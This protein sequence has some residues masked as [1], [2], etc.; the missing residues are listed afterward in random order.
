MAKADIRTL[1]A[2]EGSTNECQGCGGQLR[3]ID[4]DT[5]SDDHEFREEYKCIRCQERG[6]YV[7]TVEQ[8]YYSGV[9]AKGL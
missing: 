1:G 5:I 4:G 3:C 6:Q 9:C 7:F 8:D 2:E